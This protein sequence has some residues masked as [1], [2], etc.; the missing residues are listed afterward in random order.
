MLSMRTKQF[1]KNNAISLVE[2]SSEIIYWP[3]GTNLINVRILLAN[4]F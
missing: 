3:A 2:N 1:K 4:T